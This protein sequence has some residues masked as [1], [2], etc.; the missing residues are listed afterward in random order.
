MNQKKNISI[1]A[2][3][4]SGLQSIFLISLLDKISKNASIKKV[5]IF[6]FNT[7]VYDEAILK[8]KKI[9]DKTDYNFNFI[10]CRET[11][12]KKLENIKITYNYFI[13][14]SRVSVYHHNQFNYNRSFFIK[15]GNCENVN[16]ALYKLKYKL[17]YT[18]DDGL[19]NWRR[20]K[21]SFSIRNFFPRFHMN[22]DGKKTIS[23]QNK[24]FSN[25]TS[26]RD[27][28][29]FSIF[30]KNKNNN[31]L[32]LFSNNLKKLSSSFPKLLDVQVLYVGVWP[33]STY[34]NTNKQKVLEDDDQVKN[35]F[36]IINHENKFT[37]VIHYKDHPKF[38]LKPINLEK[39]K[40]KKINEIYNEAPLEL[41][42]NSLPNLK[43][44]YGFPSTGLFLIKALKLNRIKI[45]VIIKR[46][47]PV[48]YSDLEYLFN[49]KNFNLIY[50]N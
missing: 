29:H 11:K 27:I 35:F 1:G 8:I 2:E 46:D 13:V 49:D 16:I 30:S 40:F 20:E 41:I 9:L 10:D 22:D 14:R 32:S 38:K 18:I 25:E 6:I 28:T 26:S 7:G 42:I 19:S 31:L 15:I 33:S 44:I 39:F 48:Y 5:D 37:E 43:E 45:N 12:I 23:Y 17:L 24:L 21:N 4:T 50:I 34:R 36:S 3:V 47:D